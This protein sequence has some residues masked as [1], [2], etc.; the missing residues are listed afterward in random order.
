MF[1]NRGRTPFH[2]DTEPGP[3]P[4]DA[5]GDPHPREDLLINSDPHNV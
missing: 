5:A 1:P 4:A 3:G 2:K